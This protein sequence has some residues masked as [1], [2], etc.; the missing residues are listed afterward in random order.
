[1]A[2]QLDL[3]TPVTPPS[4]NSYQVVRIDLGWEDATINIILKSDIGG[5]LGFSY[6]GTEA[7]NLMN[8]LNKADLSANSLHKRVINQLVT[9]GKLTGTISGTPD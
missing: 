4:T 7:T 2:E 8:A 3:T 5:Y 6:I 9:D 1:M